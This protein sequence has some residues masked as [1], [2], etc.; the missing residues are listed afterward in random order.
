MDSH[1]CCIATL[2]AF[3]LVVVVS[4][5]FVLFTTFKPWGVLVGFA[6]LQVSLLVSFSARTDSVSAVKCRTF[7]GY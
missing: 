6:L 3:A 2:R 7:R 5:A 1:R 4:L